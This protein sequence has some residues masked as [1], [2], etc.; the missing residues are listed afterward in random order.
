MPSRLH[1]QTRFQQF[2][3]C[4]RCCPAHS[5]LGHSSGLSACR[6]CHPGIDAIKFNA[7][8]KRGCLVDWAACAARA[9]PVGF[10]AAKHVAG[11]REPAAEQQLNAKLGP[12]AAGSCG[13]V[14]PTRQI[15]AMMMRQLAKPGTLC[16]GGAWSRPAGRPKQAAHPFTRHICA[17]LHTLSR[18]LQLRT[19]AAGPTRRRAPAANRGRRQI[20]GR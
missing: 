15:P 20:F 11:T 9:R 1:F 17:V 18:P 3:T 6:C 14:W 10:A 13:I 4:T 8:D 2:H 7:C 16:C 5:S 12:A 19:P